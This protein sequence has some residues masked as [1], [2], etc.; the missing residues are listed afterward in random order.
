MDKVC[1]L[2]LDFEDQKL[3]VALCPDV[4]AKEVAQLLKAAF[5]LEADVIALKDTN[6]LSVYSLSSILSNPAPFSQ[7][8]FTLVL[9]NSAQPEPNN[10]EEEEEPDNDPISSVLEFIQTQTGFA[11]L[12]IRDIYQVFERV[13]DNGRWLNEAGFCEAFFDLMPRSSDPQQRQ[14][15]QVVTNRVFGVFDRDKD[16]CIDFSEFASGLA[17]LCNGSAR[18]KIELAFSLFDYDG[19][20]YISL[21]EMEKYLIS[22]FETYFSL[23]PVS[24]AKFRNATPDDVGR[25]T[26][27]NCFDEADVDG[28]GFISM[29]EFKDWYSSPA[30]VPGMSILHLVT[31]Q[32]TSK[33]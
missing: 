31:S 14:L 21:D 28:D 7:S 16:G 9:S 8:L 2:S 12:E 3:C 25:A 33:A 26:A 4:P 29:A 24:R 19:D 13:S 22:F 10:N 27:K 32:L 6:T 17:L 1:F 11:E 23:Y 15:L 18:D 5:Q 30:Q 20:G